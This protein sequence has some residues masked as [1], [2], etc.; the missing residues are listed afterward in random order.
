[1]PTEL[2]RVL[3]D[4]FGA[5]IDDVQLVEYSW[6]NALHGWPLAVTRRNRIYL[7]YSKTE[8]FAD[9]ELVLHEYFHVLQQWNTRELTLLRYL[10][11]TLR[12]GYWKN[13]FEVEARAFAARH[14]RRC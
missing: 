3:L 12:R 14:R 10:W 2:R 5:A 8:F 11:D 9:P 6:L 13:R 1:M 7:R 4:L